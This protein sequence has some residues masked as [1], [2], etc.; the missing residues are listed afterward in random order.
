M[1]PK[2]LPHPRFL[3]FLAV[4]AVASVLATVWRG[5]EIGVVWGFDLAAIAF[6]A[7]SLPLWLDDHPDKM[8][9]RAAR[10]DGGRVLLLVV[11]VIVV[12][13]VALALVGLI[14]GRGARDAAAVGVILVTL[15]LAWMFANLV[16][17]FHY[18]HVFYDQIAGKDAGGLAFP[19]DEPPLFVD[20]CYFSYVIGMTCQ[21][22]DVTVQTRSL[23]RVATVHGLFAFFF[24]LGVL[25]LTINVVSGVL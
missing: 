2:T 17:A 3:L 22:S 4:M 10:D 15:V 14:S 20:F 21:V 5:A 8:R 1:M 9:A 16:F 25:A 11:S 24:N 6:L 12:A 7:A 18:A 13:V 19:G 23:R